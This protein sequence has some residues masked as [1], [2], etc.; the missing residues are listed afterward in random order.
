VFEQHA[1]LKV[2]LFDFKSDRSDSR[3]QEI[4]NQLKPDFFLDSAPFLGPSR[5]EFTGTRTVALCYDL[6]PLLYPNFYLSN[7]QALLEYKNGIHRLVSAD[8]LIFIS[9]SVKNDFSLFFKS[10]GITSVIHPK[11]EFNF[12]LINKDKNRFKILTSI[13]MHPSKNPW[14]LALCLNS[15]AKRYPEIEYCVV[16]SSEGWESE[17]KNL[18]SNH[19]IE[20][21]S[22]LSDQEYADL[23][24][25][26]D[27]YIHASVE[28]GF[29]IPLLNATNA[30]CAV[31]AA[32]TPVNEEICSSSSLYLFDPLQ[33]DSLLSAC[34]EAI[35][36]FKCGKLRNA[37]ARASVTSD[38]KSFFSQVSAVNTLEIIN[39]L[40]PLPPK[41]CGISDYS[42]AI[43]GHLL[44]TVRINYFSDNVLSDDLYFRKNIRVYPIAEISNR[45]NHSSE[46]F[47]DV[48]QIAAAPW[49][50][51]YILEMLESRSNINTKYILHDHYIGFGLYQLFREDFKFFL[52]VFI[53][54]E[55]DPEFMDDL[56][57]AH[58]AKNT[59]VLQFLLQ[60]R[61]ILKWLNKCTGNVITHAH[62]PSG[63]IDAAL[64]PM[65]SQIP[66]TLQMAKWKLGSKVPRKMLF[67]CFGR[68]TVNKHL[69]E[70]IQAISLLRTKGVDAELII[71]GETVDAAYFIK[72]QELID[73]HGLGDHIIFAGNVSSFMYWKFFNSID[74]L[75]SLRDGS[76]GGLSAVLVNGIFLGKRIIASDIKE[77]RGYF[78]SG[79]SLVDNENLVF[80]IVGSALRIVQNVLTPLNNHYSSDTFY[81]RI[82]SS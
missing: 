74:V 11:G 64:A 45:H 42:G 75:I 59:R 79:L 66:A 31:V 20:V 24:S 72:L 10:D 30:G 28:E 25:E 35:H 29:G 26:A 58:Q 80:E 40:G 53:E 61:P 32:K 3:I 34:E 68:V 70:V 69:E 52:K 27:I 71:V 51:S 4:I 55:N 39:W 1:L 50:S 5:F 54:P 56:I 57:K 21:R 15:L 46:S 49:F 73:Q 19:R 7:D 37:E 6:I 60:S 43:V 2:R 36:D 48:F 63:T 77:H 23:I 13:G 22:N 62:P 14:Q 8:G 47:I 38:L 16:A 78:L 17:F 67:G 82:T 33:K 44:D 65:P 18:L 41:N 76:R 81:E 12:T 9:E